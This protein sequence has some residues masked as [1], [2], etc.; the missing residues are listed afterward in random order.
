[1]ETIFD[2][3]PTPEEIKAIFGEMI[4]PESYDVLDQANEYGVIYQLYRLRGDEE[5]ARFYYHKMESL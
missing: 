2:H 4:T 1:M 3:H 5:K